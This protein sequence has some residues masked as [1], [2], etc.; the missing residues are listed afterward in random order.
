M[1][2]NFDFSLCKN[3]VI[4]VYDVAFDKKDEAKK[5]GL[6]W[7]PERKYWYTQRKYDNKD[8][9]LDTDIMPNYKPFNVK[10]VFS[11]AY[12]YDEMF[13]DLIIL[14]C[15]EQPEIQEPEG[16]RKCLKCQK[17]LVAIADRRANGK[18]GKDWDS[19]NFHKKCWKELC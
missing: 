16:K 11:L 8:L 1:E 17:T 9:N 18:I 2:L 14:K 7:N 15:N 4:F 6:K 5:M 13:K 3:R 10:Q 12:E 19:R